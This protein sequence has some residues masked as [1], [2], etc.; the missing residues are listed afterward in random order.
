M[1]AQPKNTQQPTGDRRGLR[2]AI[3]PDVVDNGLEII[4]A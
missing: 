2:D 3:D 4:A 1:P